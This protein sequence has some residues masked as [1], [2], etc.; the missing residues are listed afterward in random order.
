M[1][2]K[3]KG[4][5][6]RWVRYVKW[7]PKSEYYEKGKEE[8]SLMRQALDLRGQLEKEFEQ[9]EEDGYDDEYDDEYDEESLS[10]SDEGYDDPVLYGYDDDD[11]DAR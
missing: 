6:N 2:A 1:A 4:P 8:K 3:A 11:Y 9:S 7:F 5:A 10:A